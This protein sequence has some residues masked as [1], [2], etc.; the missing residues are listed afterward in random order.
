MGWVVRRLIYVEILARH[1]WMERRGCFP[2]LSYS[3]TP[4][5]SYVTL[6]LP[7]GYKHFYLFCFQI[8][9]PRP[10]R[11]AGRKKEGSEGEGGAAAATYVISCYAVLRVPC[12]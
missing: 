2:P 8:V 5:T 1:Q 4:G 9:V 10:R 3:V 12:M 6:Q 11:V 7:R